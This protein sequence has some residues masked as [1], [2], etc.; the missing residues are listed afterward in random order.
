MAAAVLPAREAPARAP[1]GSR[2]NDYILNLRVRRRFGRQRQ[3]DRQSRQ[4][5]H[6]RELVVVFAQQRD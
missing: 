2:A 1:T 4:S 6:E 3:Y 5:V